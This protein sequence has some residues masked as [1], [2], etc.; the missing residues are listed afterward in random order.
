MIMTCVLFVYHIFHM[1]MTLDGPIIT[2][3]KFNFL[4]I[5]MK[6]LLG[7]NITMHGI[8]KANTFLDQIFKV[9]SMLW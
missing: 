8:P 1:K 5:N 3:I 4:L 9:P 7:L 6:I 2:F